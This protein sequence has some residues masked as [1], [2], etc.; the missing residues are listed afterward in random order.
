M[1]MR[2][3]GAIVLFV[4]CLAFTAGASS[5]DIADCDRSGDNQV[6]VVDALITLQSAVNNC[7]ADI[8]CDADG[9]LSETVSDALAL[10]RYAVGL[11]VELDCTCIFIDECFEDS[12]CVV[13]YPPGYFCAGYTCV[14][15]DAES[16]CAPGFVCDYCSF[17]CGPGTQ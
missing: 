3:L 2:D 14:E 15:C 9:D 16:D 11:P 10:L 17:T 7:V 12:D 5:A 13:G 4:A 6:T 8:L 1:V